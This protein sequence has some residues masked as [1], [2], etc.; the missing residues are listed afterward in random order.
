MD[1]EFKLHYNAE[2]VRRKTENSIKI[3][4]YQQGLE[5]GVSQGLEQ[6][7]EQGSK[8]KEIE[9]A[10]KLL[11]LGTISVSDIS[12]ITGLTTEEIRIL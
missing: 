6:G 10:K 12:K 1:E 11:N 4:S 5:E 2:A 3:E 7:L 9:I 8:Q